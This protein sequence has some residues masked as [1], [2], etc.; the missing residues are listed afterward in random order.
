MPKAKEEETP[1]S[2]KE[3]R[4]DV[5][6]KLLNRCLGANSKL[7]GGAGRYDTELH[8]SVE[9]YQSFMEGRKCAGDED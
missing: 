2:L 7:S 6:R 1:K 5:E 3:L 4:D 9:T 8:V